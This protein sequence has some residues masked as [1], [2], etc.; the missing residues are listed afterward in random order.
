VNVRFPQAAV[1]S[2][3]DTVWQPLVA[4]FKER[5]AANRSTLLFVN[6]RR[7]CEKLTSM[8]NSGEP[9]PLAYSHH[10]SLSREIREEVER[11]LK[12]GELRGIVATNSLEMGIDIGALDEV[13]LVQAPKSVSSAVQRVGR[14][15]HSVG[16]VSRGTLVP[17]HSLDFL[18]SAV[19]AEGILSQDIE[20]VHPVRAPLDVL[21]QVLISMVGVESWDI[22]DLFNQVRCAWSYRELPRRQFDL[23]LEMLAGRYADSRIREL[24]PRVSI[25]RLENRV[26]GQK[27][28]LQTL[29]MSGGTIPDRGYFHLRHAENGARIG[30]LDEEFVWEARVGQTFTLGTQHWRVDRITHSDVMVTPS[31]STKPAPPFWKG[32]DLNRDY[33][34]SEKIATFLE[35]AETRLGDSD[36]AQELMDRFRM[37]TAATEQL[38]AFLERQ[39]EVTGCAL[40][41]R[42][43]IVVEFVKTMMG[44]ESGRQVVLHTCWGGKVNRPFGMAL[45]AAWEERF[46]L[47]VEVFVSNDSVV[48]VSQDEVPAA[49]ILSLVTTA[50]VEALLRRKLEESGFFG[51]RFREC[52]GRALLVTRSRMGQ[53]MP[54]WLTR[55]RSQKLFDSVLSY[56]DFPILLETWRTCLQDEMDLPQLQ[57][58]LGELESNA[59]RW[60]EAHTEVASP[61]ARTTTWNQINRYMYADDAPTSGKRSSLTDDL[62]REVAFSAD[63]R[64]MLGAELVASFERK[65][66]RLHPGYAPTGPHELLDWVK[67]RLAIPGDEWADLLT[68]IDRDGETLLTEVLGAVEG[69]L[70]RIRASGGQQLIVALESSA[71]VQSAL[72]GDADAGL[73]SFTDGQPVEAPFADVIDDDGDGID[74][75][76]LAEWLR[77]YGPLSLDAIE[78]KLGA[79]VE[80]L[81]A[82]L[83]DF[84]ETETVVVGS[85]VEGGSVDEICDA[86][87]LEFLLRLS[88]ADARPSFQPLPQKSIPLFLATLHGLTAHPP[89]TGMDAI[90]RR[91]EQ[92]LCYSL[93]ADMWES[94]V[95][96]AR[97]RPYD[98]SWM[99][100]LMGESDMRWVGC[101]ANRTAFCFE[102]DLDLL[103]GERSEGEGSGTGEGREEEAD[104]RLK[105]G[106]TAG[107]TSDTAFVVPEGDGQYDFAALLKVTGMSSGVLAERLWEEVW[108]GNVTNTTYQALRKGIETRFNTDA[109]SGTASGRGRRPGPR[110]NFRRWKTTMPFGGSWRRLPE[111]TGEADGAIDEEER[112]RDRVRLLLDRYG[113]LFR[114]LVQRELP[115]FQWSKLFRSLRLM[116]LSGEI[117]SGYFFEG[118]PGPQF[119]SHSA[120]RLLSRALPEKAVYWLNASDPVSMC[121]TGL[122]ELRATLP[123]RHAGTHLVYRGDEVVVISE[124]Q[125]K[126]LTIKI[127]PDDGDLLEALGV[128]GHLMGRAAQPIR[129]IRI[130]TINDE[131]A[132]KSPYVD[133]LKTLFEVRV[134]FREVSVFRK[135]G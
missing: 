14:A 81:A 63:F 119:I 17:T 34:F 24:K 54:L 28:S 53:R 78:G 41:H 99:D 52:A 92:L 114:E 4:D 23:V 39:R 86:E 60:T 113:V 32:E 9:K 68:A 115:P 18:E 121:G 6:N 108:E 102:G 43:H 62:L 11:K 82:A 36:Y 3:A 33:H 49:D 26:T 56:P 93:P 126:A 105:A 111:V 47:P 117:L 94:E 116:E 29:Y 125:G 51:A 46:D 89:D 40:P 22:D 19:L 38:L 131:E 65:R 2:E 112:R 42:H 30:E 21:A 80:R 76:V 71:R 55:V 96:P 100:T 66:Q 10:G 69:M 98:G 61:M 79:P 97:I 103:G 129:R 123:R 5:V 120:F 70:A 37:D 91:L 110:A 72:F 95:L 12:A 20:A 27:G 74:S 124:R 16:E 77:F 130:E 88:R 118:I 73:L 35:D 132:A 90:T 57:Q 104:S 44:T 67:E 128:L 59:I 8:I 1:D 135:M 109:T 122:D 15:G 107:R 106:R 83:E 7:L 127:P 48:L 13:I 75:Q 25:D 133:V 58:L 45:E 134:E 50:G 87:N 31:R 64:P 85:L 84:A 101:G